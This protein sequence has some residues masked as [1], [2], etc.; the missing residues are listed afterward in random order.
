MMMSSQGTGLA[1]LY[2]VFYF[3]VPKPQLSWEGQAALGCIHYQW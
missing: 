3:Q 1:M 2:K